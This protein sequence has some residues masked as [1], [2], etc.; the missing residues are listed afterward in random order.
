MNSSGSLAPGMESTVTLTGLL[1][2]KCR[3]RSVAFWPA[4][5]ES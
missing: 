1:S 2:N 4:S 5:S 3:L